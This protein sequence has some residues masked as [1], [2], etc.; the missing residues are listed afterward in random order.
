MMKIFIVLGTVLIF[1]TFNS[2]P[3]HFLPLAHA[4]QETPSYAKW[5]K[6]AVKETHSKYPDANIIDYKHIGSESKSDS[7]IE[8][9]KL[10]LKD[11]DGI[12]RFCKN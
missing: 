2:A 12:W 4:Q 8:N 6:L 1:I 9:F 3:R 5:G 11:G 10:W 7:T